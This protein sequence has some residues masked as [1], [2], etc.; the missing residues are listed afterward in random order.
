MLIFYFVIFVEEGGKRVIYG[1]RL[2]AVYKKETWEEN[3]EIQL[4]ALMA[5]QPGN[6]QIRKGERFCEED[7]KHFHFQFNNQIVK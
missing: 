5:K 7:T 1:H 3:N 6:Q 4:L 2:A